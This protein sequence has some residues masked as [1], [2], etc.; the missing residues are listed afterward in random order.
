MI[1]GNDPEEL[2][3]KIQ[4]YT[5]CLVSLVKSCQGMEYFGGVGIPVCR[6]SE[7]R[8][9]FKAASKAY[10]G[11]YML[12]YNQILRAEEALKVHEEWI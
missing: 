1:M 5:K 7:I 12:E 10:A 6:L 2:E 3:H 9:S 4:S 11:R 8:A